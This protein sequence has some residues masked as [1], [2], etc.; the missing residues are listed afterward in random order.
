MNHVSDTLIRGKIQ[1][2]EKELDGVEMMEDI[3]EEMTGRISVT[4]DLLALECSKINALAEL[5]RQLSDMMSIPRTSVTPPREGKATRT[6]VS[7]EIM[8]LQQLLGLRNPDDVQKLLKRGETLDEQLFH[9]GIQ[10]IKN[11]MDE[12]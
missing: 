2:M 1:K 8:M 12:T 4:R 5:L 6:E 11:A 9:A 10:Y 7:S 3:L